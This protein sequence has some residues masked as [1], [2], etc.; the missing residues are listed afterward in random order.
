[1]MKPLLETLPKKTFE[2]AIALSIEKEQQE[3]LR[4][5]LIGLKDCFP[6]LPKHY[7]QQQKY[8][9]KIFMLI[10]PLYEHYELDHVFF[11]FL[12]QAASILEEMSIM[13]FRQKRLPEYFEKVAM[14]FQ[15]AADGTEIKDRQNN[16]IEKAKFYIQKANEARNKFLP[17]EPVDFSISHEKRMYQ[18]FRF[19]AENY[20]EDSVYNKP[21]FQKLADNYYKKYVLIRFEEIRNSV[22]GNHSDLQETISFLESVIQNPDNNCFKKGAFRM[23][24]SINR[25]QSHVERGFFSFLFFGRAD[26]MKELLLVQGASESKKRR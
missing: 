20:C 3:P 17:N 18:L 14:V 13:G 19:A 21:Y 24:E 26:R 5:N 1:M 7:D 15:I 25:Q 2:L 11:D 9:D 4:L 8:I 12:I 22:L 6:L 23:L 10:N 16:F